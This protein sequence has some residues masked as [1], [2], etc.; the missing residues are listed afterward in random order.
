MNCY[1]CGVRGV[2]NPAVAACHSCG[3]GVC[4]EC[5]RAEASR[6]DQP[7]TVGIPVSGSTRL[8]L[9]PSCDRAMAAHALGRAG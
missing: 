2:Q 9:C 3:A 7:A 6:V 1:D 4:V 8:L 5:V